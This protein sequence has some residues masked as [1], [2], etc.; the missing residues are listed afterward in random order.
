MR[1]RVVGAQLDRLEEVGLRIL[2][3]PVVQERDIGERDVGLREAGIDRERVAGGGASLGHGDARRVLLV[4]PVE[5]RAQQQIGVRE[6]D[7]RER[8]VGVLGLRPLEQLDRP[9]EGLVGSPV[10]LVAS[11]P[12]RAIG[13]AV[14][15]LRGADALRLFAGQLEP[16][17]L[18]DL[19][20]DVVLDRDDVLEGAIVLLAPE[21]RAAVHVDELGLNVQVT[22]TL[23][24][25]PRE[26]GAD[27]ELP[28]DGLRIFV[29]VPVAERRAARLHLELRQ[30]REP[31]DQRL[32][33]AVA[34]I[35][36]VGIVPRVLE[37][38]HRERRDGALLGGRRRLGAV[39]EKRRERDGDHGGRDREHAELSPGS[40]G[41]T[42]LRCGL[43][44]AGGGGRTQPG[45]LAVRVAAHAFQIRHQILRGLVPV[46]G[47]LLER[48]HDDA[49]EL[50]GDL[51][52]VVARRPRA[53]VEDGVVD[54]PRGR[55]LERQVPAGHLV[56]HDAQ[57]EDVG[58]AVDG[59]AA[60]LLGRHVD[61]RA[62]GGAS[63]GHLS[64]VGLDLAVGQRL[65]REELRDSEVEDL[66]VTA[67]RD[68]DVRGLD[69]AVDD[70]LVV[71]GLERVGE[72]DGEVERIVQGKGA[73]PNPRLEGLALDVLHGDE[74]LAVALA[75][76][77]DLA[78]VGVIERSGGARFA[79]EPLA[80]VVVLLER[81]GQELDRHL[82]PEHGV[83]RQK[84]AAHAAPAERLD[85]LELLPGFAGGCHGARDT[86]ADVQAARRRTLTH[87]DRRIQ[88]VGSAEVFVSA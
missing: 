25:A 29:G 19:L 34:E 68:D 76:L 62:G 42:G 81:F 17:R 50:L 14:G 72:L 86:A 45:G 3:V 73:L 79:K 16:Q 10:P 27:V 63:R 35:V 41:R 67:A 8:E 31:V 77:V 80:S 36:D 44:C 30:G 64:R 83:L 9:L 85:E 13:L 46:S 20:R 23:D 15:R 26:D 58:P 52:V 54:E 49:L 75:D 82:A 74:R 2:P 59:F 7:V 48:L 70:L 43:R 51:R 71:R 88:T 12:V 6:A 69:V 66:G 84:D 65:G 61:H 4:A 47:V 60:H 56:E 55:A 32:R 87:R 39:P 38:E 21:L 18:G 24:H 53:E 28:A 1:D 78:D 22:V 33:D 5:L 57:R 11:L 40:S 37:R